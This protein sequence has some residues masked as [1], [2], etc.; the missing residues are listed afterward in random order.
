MKRRKLTADEREANASVRIARA[1]RGLGYGSNQKRALMNGIA[2]SDFLGFMEQ[3]EI[4]GIL[5]I[6]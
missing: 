5:K 2:M 1:I 6:P 4:R 3:R